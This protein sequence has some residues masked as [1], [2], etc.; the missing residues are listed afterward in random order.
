MRFLAV[1]LVGFVMTEALM[2]VLVPKLGLNVTLAKA[3][4]S[5]AVMIWNFGLNK[6]WTFRQPA[7][8]STALSS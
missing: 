3:L 7:V 4:T 1:S 8:S 6:F 2:W 5:M